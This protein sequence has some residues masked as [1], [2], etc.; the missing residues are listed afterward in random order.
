MDDRCVRVV[1]TKQNG[2]KGPYVT[3][4]HCWGKG[5]MLKLT[6]QN[7]KRFMDEGVALEK[8]SL[9]H[10]QAIAVTRFL[11]VR[12]LWI[13]SL[14]IVQGEDGDFDVERDLMHQVYRNSYCNIAAADSRD[15]SGGL[16]RQRE[17]NQILSARY[18]ASGES[19]MFRPGVWRIVPEDL[20]DT[21]L[22]GAAL[23]SRAWVFQGM[24]KGLFMQCRLCY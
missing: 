22:L 10:Q 9:N 18:V 20:W 15:G 17:A 23:Y 16:F 1:E 3:L 8:L 19:A 7:K 12:Y 11:D 21:Q 24:L 4:S 14:C 5:E 2:I 13:D 6:L